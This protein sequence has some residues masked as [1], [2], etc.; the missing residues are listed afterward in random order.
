MGWIAETS[1][2]ELVA[3]MADADLDR[4]GRDLYDCTRLKSDQAERFEMR[5]PDYGARLCRTAFGR[6]L[7]QFKHQI[8]LC[9][10][11]RTKGVDQN[12]GSVEMLDVT[13]ADAVNQCIARFRPSHVVHL[14]GL[15]AIRTAIANTSMAW[16]VHLFGTLNVANA[17]L[18]QTP[19]CILIFVGSGQVYGASARLGHPLDETALLDPTNGY[20]VTKAPADLALG[21]LAA[22]QGLRC[23]RLRPFNHTGPGQRE[24]FVIPSFALQIA[25]I[26]AGQ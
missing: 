24:D 10:T 20:E 26:E 21:A 3:E 8:E 9:I 6:A 4:L 18:G 22:A 5:G 11:S 2:E 17:I 19:N 14:A 7:R 12:L 16:Q 13:D 15:A 23:I 1:L 25:R